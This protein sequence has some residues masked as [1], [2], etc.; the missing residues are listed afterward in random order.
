MNILQRNY[1][2]QYITFNIFPKLFYV[3]EKTHK[4]KTKPPKQTAKH[5]MNYNVSLLKTGGHFY[6][7]TIRNMNI[8]PKEHWIWHLQL[9]KEWM[10]LVVI[11]IPK[12]WVVH[13]YQQNGKFYSKKCIKHVFIKL[14]D[15]VIT[16][17]A[18]QSAATIYSVNFAGNHWLQ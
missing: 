11:V 6:Y 4:D 17:F 14:Y 3:T 12:F 10:Q 13:Y 7:N 2:I 5:K 18:L 1:I 16:A 9:T 15:N 8:S